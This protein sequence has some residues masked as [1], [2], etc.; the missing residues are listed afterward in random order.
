M[1]SLFFSLGGSSLLTL[2][3]SWLAFNNGVKVWLEW[4]VRQARRDDAWPPVDYCHCNR[5]GFLLITSFVAVGTP[6]MLAVVLGA[7][8]LINP[9]MK[10]KNDAAI[11]GYM[12]FV[13]LLIGLLVVAVL[14]FKD[15]VERQIA[16]SAPEACWGETFD[17]HQE[18]YLADRNRI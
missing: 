2:A 9:W 5:A 18:T 16:A 14:R 6:T 8:F 13:L 17:D 15:F 4:R 12:A 10:Q 3:A 1:L 7:A 11:I